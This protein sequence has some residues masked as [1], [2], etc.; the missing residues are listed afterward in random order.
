MG[1]VG[2]GLHI[3]QH[4]GLAE[5]S[6]DRRKGWTGSGLAPL[7]FNGVHQRRFLAADESTCAQADMHIKAEIR[8]ED[9][10][11]QQAIGM[12]LLNGHLQPLHRNG[13]LRTNI[14]VSLAGTNGVTANGHG[15]NDGMRI[16]FQQG[17]IHEGTRIALICV[18]GNVFLIRLAIV[19]KEPLLACRESAAATSTEAGIDDFLNHLLPGH[20][21][22]CLG[23]CLIAVKGNVLFNILR[24]NHAAVPQGNT[25][26]LPI[27]TNLIQCH[28]DAGFMGHMIHIHQVLYLASLQQ[29]LRHNLIHVLYLDAAVESPFRVHNHYRTGFA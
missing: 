12:C 11:S 20:F 1:N 29:V 10:L 5:Q 3:V 4:R 14:N 8:T 7:A 22:K 9:V 2:V 17:T 28:I 25:L 23:Q 27:E 13:I 6:L 24:I 19:A 18:T 15:F 26:L 21:R 16:T